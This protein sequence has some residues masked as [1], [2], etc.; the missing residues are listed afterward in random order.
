MNRAES[1]WRAALAEHTQAAA[2]YVAAGNQ[3]GLEAWQRPWSPGKWSPAQLTEHLSVTYRVLLSELSGGEGMRLK[4]SPFRRAMLRMVV[5]PH[6]L[7]HRTFPKRAPAP[8]EVRP[9][10]GP[11]PAQAEALAQLSGLAEALNQAGERAKAEGRRSVTHAYFG[12]LD[13]TRGMRLCAVHL[14]HH[15]R[16]LRRAGETP[17]P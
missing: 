9:G 4:L 6:M 5:L 16:Q 3:L 7:F 2:A 13:L 12:P 8:R 10:D 1:R 14:E 15:G 17:S 11:F